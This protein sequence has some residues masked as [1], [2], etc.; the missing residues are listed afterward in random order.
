MFCA[1]ET[2]PATKKMHMPVR[3]DIIMPPYRVSPGRE[4]ADHPRTLLGFGHSFFNPLPDC[5]AIGRVHPADAV[6]PLEQSICFRAEKALA[7]GIFYCGAH[8]K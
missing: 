7:F 2:H 4:K 8:I 5:A 1:F 6:P 3:E